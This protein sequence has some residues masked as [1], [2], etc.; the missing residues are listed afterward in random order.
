MAIYIYR[1]SIIMYTHIQLVPHDLLENRHDYKFPPWSCTLLQLGLVEEIADTHNHRLLNDHVSLNWTFLEVYNLYLS[2]LLWL[3]AVHIY[4]DFSCEWPLK[5]VIELPL[6][7]RI[8]NVKWV[9]CPVLSPFGYICK[10]KNKMVGSLSDS[11]LSCSAH[12]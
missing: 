5:R 10:H 9:F 11:Y 8:N 3:V 4:V 12:S 1:Y 2:P 7:M 6:I